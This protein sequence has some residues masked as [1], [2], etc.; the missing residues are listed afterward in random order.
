MLKFYHAPWSR[1]SSVLWLL[2]ELGVEYELT[3]IDIRQEGGV[4]ENYRRIQPS[5]K[6]PAIEHDGVVITER[7][8]ITIYLAEAFPNAGLAP[9]VGHPMRGPYLSMLVYCDSVFDPALAAKVQGWKYESNHF[10]FGL[11]DDMVNYIDRILTERP[12]AAGDRFTAADTQLASSIGY[13]MQQMKALPERP[14]F[15][16]YMDRVKDRPANLRAAEKDQE[17]AIKTPFFQKQFAG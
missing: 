8:A 14:S 13:T 4:P 16:A 3:E 15:I 12:Y 7:A 6:V 1:S 2:E 11:A 10:S 5:K 9:A 17:M